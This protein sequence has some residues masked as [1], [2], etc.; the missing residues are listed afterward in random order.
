MDASQ[1]EPQ[2]PGT[3]GVPE[4]V[5]DTLREL[6]ERGAVAYRAEAAAALVPEPLMERIE[7][8]RERR[9]VSWA[10]TAAGLGV[11]VVASLAAGVAGLVS[12]VRGASLFSLLLPGPGMLTVALPFAIAATFAWV[13]LAWLGPVDVKRLAR[14]Y[15]ARPASPGELPVTERALAT[16]A[17]AFGLGTPPPLLV[18]DAPALNAFS[19]GRLERG[20]VAVTRTLAGAMSEDEQQAVFAHLLARL[21]LGAA[22]YAEGEPTVEEQADALAMQALRF[23]DAMLDALERMRTADTALPPKGLGPAAYFFA[24]QMPTLGVMD[25]MRAAQVDVRIARMRAV[26][27]AAAAGE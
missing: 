7:R 13:G 21:V 3:E 10:V 8:D 17:L 5:L 1:H 11:A 16:I 19:A 14:A 27:G 26:L 25:S 2:A 18:T 24:P 15:G 22:P 9:R 6:S 4:V 20:V 12:Y 23:P